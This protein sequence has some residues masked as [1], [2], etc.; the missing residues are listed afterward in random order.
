MPY[1]AVKVG[2]KPGVYNTWTECEANIK[3]IDKATFKKFDS[4]SDAKSFINSNNSI[5]KYNDAAKKNAISNILEAVKKS[6]LEQDNV[7]KELGEK[8]SQVVD[9]SFDFNHHLVL[10]LL[11]RSAR[12][13]Q[14]KRRCRASFPRS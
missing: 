2:K 12:K 6:K 7:A 10:G 13:H 14:P 5:Q 1:Y 4:E 9:D 8:S 11:S 3:G